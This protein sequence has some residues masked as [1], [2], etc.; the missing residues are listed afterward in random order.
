VRFKLTREFFTPKGATK[1]ADKQSDAIAYLYLTHEGQP[2]AATFFG[3][4]SKPAWRFRYTTEARREKAVREGFESRRETLGRLASR[5]AERKAWIPT[6]KVGDILKTCWGYDQTNVEYFEITE[7]RGK[8]VILRELAQE[9]VDT[10][11]LQGRCVPLPGKYLTP[12][13]E[14]DD[15]GTPIRRLAQQGG[16][17]ID[18]VRY[19]YPVDTETVAGIKVVSPS[20]WSSYH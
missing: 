13:H 19:A 18:N 20:H 1:V 5:K 6:Y 2:A 17:K 3:K 16:I 4:Q 7:V 9:R 11:W 8:H 14:G 15:A 12:R 10:G